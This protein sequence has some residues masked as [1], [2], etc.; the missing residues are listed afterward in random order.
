MKVRLNAKTST[1]AARH[2]AQPHIARMSIVGFVTT[3]TQVGRRAEPFRNKR[4]WACCTLL[5][6]ST[7]SHLVA[8]YLGEH[9]AENM[10]VSMS[11]EI[12]YYQT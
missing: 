11:K 7:S 5:G 12:Q 4:A 1:K 8:S 6:K 2:G 3:E 9:M 10:G